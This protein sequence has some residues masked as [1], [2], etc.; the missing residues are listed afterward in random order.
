[1]AKIKE[2]KVKGKPDNY[3]KYIFMCPGCEE[4]HA[5]N[6]TWVFNNDFEKPTV[7]PSI[8]L[9]WGKHI[10]KRCHSFIK[11]GKI[12]FLNDCHHKLKGQTVDL[13]ECNY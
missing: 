9:T 11:N 7:S 3:K 10:N 8:L 5:F 4:Y 13:T 12:Q 1:M 6:N 2:Y